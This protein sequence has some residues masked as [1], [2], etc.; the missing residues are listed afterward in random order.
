MIEAPSADVLANGELDLTVRYIDGGLGVAA[1]YGIMD[2]VE[3]GINN[4]RTDSNRRLG[5]VFKGVIYRETERQPAVAIGLETGQSYAAVSKRLVP[6][7]RLHAG[8]GIG[9]IDGLFAG[10]S[11]SL[12]TVSARGVASPV[13]TLLGEYTPRGLNVGA[14]MVFSPILSADVALIDLNEATLG[15]NMR[16]R[17]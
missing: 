17:F 3:I 8:Y 12:S 6:G 2:D 15:L 5:I 7:L 16:L 9:R 1:A 4:I 11:Y 13:T 14:R 10:V